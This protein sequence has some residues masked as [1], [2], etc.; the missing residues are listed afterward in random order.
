MSN[1]EKN[2]LVFVILCICM[3]SLFMNAIATLPSQNNDKLQANMIKIPYP[4]YSVYSI[5]I[6][7]KL[8]NNNNFNFRAVFR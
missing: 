4:L 1:R 8:K 7:C 3:W 5:L 2:C 6:E